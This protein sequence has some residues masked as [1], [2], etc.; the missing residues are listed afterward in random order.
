MMNAVFMQH[1]RRKSGVAAR[2]RKILNVEILGREWETFNFSFFLSTF[3]DFLWLTVWR[4]V[5]EQFF[6]LVLS[7]RE[8]FNVSAFSF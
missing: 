4:K 8:F 2:H 5:L 6:S 7:K 3:Y 1:N